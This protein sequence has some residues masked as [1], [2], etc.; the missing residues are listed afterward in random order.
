MIYIY[1]Y[2]YNYIL[3]PQNFSTT[4]VTESPNRPS[5]EIG[6]SKS[7]FVLFFDVCDSEPKVV[8]NWHKTCHGPSHC[9]SF[10][11]GSSKRQICSS[12]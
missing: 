6:A 12:P 3:A 10:M 5:F 9:S 11:F 7:F 4:V 8:L 1:I 2:I